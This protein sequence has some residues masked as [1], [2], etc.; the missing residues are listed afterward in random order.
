M[1]N[2]HKMKTPNTLPPVSFKEGGFNSL[3]RAVRV[4]YRGPTASGPSRWIARINDGAER[5]VSVRSPFLYGDSDGRREAAEKA[6]RAFCVKVEN[7]S[8]AEIFA[9]GWDGND[10][11]FFFRC[12]PR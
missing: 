7:I 5:F 3:G 4:S 1:P 8:G 2:P 6:V 12:L 9:Q 11:L 10:H